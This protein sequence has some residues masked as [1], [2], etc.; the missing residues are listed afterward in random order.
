MMLSLEIIESKEGVK[1]FLT[2]W[3]MLEI[4][5]QSLFYQR[6]LYYQSYCEYLMPPTA[7]PYLLVFSDQGK[8][9]G[10]FPWVKKRLSRF[11][12]PYYHIGSIHHDH[13]NLSDVLFD[14]NYLNSISELFKTFLKML[15]FNSSVVMRD[16]R[17]DSQFFE[18]LSCLSS[19][20]FEI[21]SGESFYIDFNE[22]V[23]SVLPKR[24]VK[25]VKRLL[26]KA[27]DTGVVEF[28]F[29][30]GDEI[31]TQA[32]EDFLVVESSGWKGQSGTETA[33]TLNPKLKSYYQSFLQAMPAKM[34]L[35]MF[36]LN[37]DPIAAHYCFKDD[38]CLSLAKVGYIEEHKSLSPSHVL[39][40]QAIQN[41]GLIGGGNRI[42]FVT[43]AG[44]L[45]QWYPKSAKLFTIY[46]PASFLGLV[47]LTVVKWFKNLRKIAK[48]K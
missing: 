18:L 10:V 29:L 37:G 26:R 33:I 20:A 12:I 39:I 1:Q 14:E 40:Y 3:E 23:D 47:V 27:N 25:N 32:F 24:M 43:G 9:V 28:K 48:K 44:W 11:G 36:Y 5:Q 42:S 35:S 8:I 15:P 45:G 46:L 7:S 31:T 30:S 2:T 13:I 21:E 38:H 34:Q 41:A 4:S 22:D 16:L 19:K 17:D 6:A